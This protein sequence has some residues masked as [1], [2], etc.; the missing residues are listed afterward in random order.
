[1]WLS[2]TMLLQVLALPLL[3]AAAAAMVERLGARFLAWQ[4]ERV[5][6][7][8]QLLGIEEEGGMG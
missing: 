3:P 5:A 1:M 8:H 4:E 7:A 2:N 6:A